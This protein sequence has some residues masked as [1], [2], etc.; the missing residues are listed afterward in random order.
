MVGFRFRSCVCVAVHL[1]TA[2]L[3]GDKVLKSSSFVQS[4]IYG[5]DAGAALGSVNIITNTD[6]GNTAA[7]S[8]SSRHPASHG[9]CAQW[10]TPSPSWSE[11]K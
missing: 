4:D 9:Q 10:S 8:A 7:A 5:I 2:V 6:G 3:G 11:R 1:L